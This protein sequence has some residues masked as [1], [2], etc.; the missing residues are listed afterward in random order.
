MQMEFN[1][2][3]LRWCLMTLAC[4]TILHRNFDHELI[5]SVEKKKLSMHQQTGI[6]SACPY[7]RLQNNILTVAT[8]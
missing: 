8:K 2:C 3:L 4:K 6:F 5:Y 7:F 1:L